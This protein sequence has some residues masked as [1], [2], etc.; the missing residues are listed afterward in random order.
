MDFDTFGG[1]MRLARKDA[2]LTLKQFSKVSGVASTLISQYER[3]EV[4][5]RITTARK[6][7]YALG[8]SIDEYIGHEVK[9]QIDRVSSF[10]LE[11]IKD[12]HLSEKGGGEN[13]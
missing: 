4:I 9:K 10:N 3:N 5:P 2:G 12:A 8:I 7:A 13:G 6:L 11:Y 1:S